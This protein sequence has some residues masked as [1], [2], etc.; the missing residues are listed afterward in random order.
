MVHYTNIQRLNTQEE[1]TMSL[2]TTAVK[3]GAKLV[4]KHI[5]KEMPGKITKDAIKQTAKDT[6]KQVATNK[7]NNAIR[8]KTYQMAHNTTDKL[9]KEAE[10]IKNPLQTLHYE[11]MDQSAKLHQ[12]QPLNRQQQSTTYTQLYNSMPN[13]IDPK[14]QYSIMSQTQQI[15][16][17][18]NSYN[19]NS[20]NN[21]IAYTNTASAIRQNE[22]K[23]R[24]YK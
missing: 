16:N 1:Y 12:G 2:L 7:V 21:S 22:L 8:Y 15:M 18:T 9:K 14:L 23:N 4:G 6:A 3:Q 10:Q 19:I 5:L 24:R 17:N 13:T 11:L 20:H